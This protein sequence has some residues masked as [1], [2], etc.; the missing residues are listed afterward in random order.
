MHVSSTTSKLPCHSDTSF[1]IVAQG[2]DPEDCNFLLRVE[3]GHVSRQVLWFRWLNQTA[4]TPRTTARFPRYGTDKMHKFST[5]PA[6]AP[7][8]SRSLRRLPT[9][10]FIAA[11]T[12]VLTAIM[13]EQLLSVLAWLSGRAPIASN[14]PQSVL[15]FSS[16][17]QFKITIF[18]DLHFGEDEYTDW[19]PRADGATLNVMS[20]I[21]DYEQPQ[22]AVLNGDLISGDNTYLT[23]S[24]DYLDMLVSPLVAHNTP[25]ASTYGNHDHNFN[26]SVSALL[27][28]ERNYP[29]SHTNQMVFHPEAG[30]SNYYVPIYPPSPGPETPPALILYW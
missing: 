18:E 15:T 13:R 7:L 4:A 6:G 23:N 1:F 19:A 14:N 11:S 17:N 3:T 24:T 29:L 10:F 30:V 5:T 26:L 22:L 12:L 27:A 28:R 8:A 2:R 25:W 21:L 16:T 20:S 9:V